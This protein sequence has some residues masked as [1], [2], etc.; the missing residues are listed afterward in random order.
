MNAN[1]TGEREVPTGALQGVGQVAWGEDAT[2]ASSAS[3]V[4]AAVAPMALHVGARALSAEGDAR[5]L[6]S[7]AC[8]GRASE[9]GPAPGGRTSFHH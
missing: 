3:G 4:E 7:T 5:A 1:G 2:A 9:C 6:P 8:R